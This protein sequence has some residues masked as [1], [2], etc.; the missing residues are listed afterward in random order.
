MEALG[1][2]IDNGIKVV[3]GRLLEMPGSAP[4]MEHAST[5]DPFL[6][7][8]LAEI[9]AARASTRAAKFEYLP[10][11]DVVAGIFLRDSGFSTNAD[12]GPGNGSV[13]NTANWAAGVVVTIPIKGLFQASADVSAQAANERLAR[14]HY[15][16]V[17]LAIQKQ[18]ET[19]LAILDGARKIDTN[20]PTELAAARATQLQDTAR[21]R[22]GLATVVDVAEADRILTQAEVDNAVARVNVWRAMLLLARAVG[23]LDPLLTEIRNASGGH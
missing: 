2:G 22:G 9:S 10:R 21:Y 6:H 1:G 15:D 13:P 3:S 19:A 16:Q 4:V 20:T 14:A 7:E 8:A 18:I 5:I 11:V 17:T 23:D 12:P